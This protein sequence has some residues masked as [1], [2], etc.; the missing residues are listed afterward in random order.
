MCYI[1]GDFEE[2]EGE[3]PTCGRCQ[4]ELGIKPRNGKK[5]GKRMEF[6]TD[7]KYSARHRTG[8]VE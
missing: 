7:R 1:R 8:V 6:L 2:V 3:A 5:I 4:T